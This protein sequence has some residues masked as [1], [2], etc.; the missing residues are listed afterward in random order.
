MERRE[1]RLVGTG[2]QGQI[3]AAIILAEAAAIHEGMNAVQTQSYGPESRGGASKAEV[4]ISESE[5]DYPHVVEP[6]VLLTMSQ[7]GFDVYG[8]DLREGGVRIVDTTWVNEPG[9]VAGVT[10]YALPITSIARQELGRQIVANVVALGVMA[11]LT[12]IVSADSLRKA[13]ANRVPEG[14]E[15]I[16]EEALA[17]GLQKAE[18]IRE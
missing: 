15:E 13:V 10:T 3:L 18:E 12:G 7:E 6:D 2:G 14:T 17:V 16:N 5:I 11:G 4:V 8:Q 1:V 9:E